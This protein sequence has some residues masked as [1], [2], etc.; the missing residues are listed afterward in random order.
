[1]I[2][3]ICPEC[4]QRIQFDSEPKI[5]QKLIC[6]TCNT[7]LLVTWLFPISLDFLDTNEQSAIPPEKGSSE[8]TFG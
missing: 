5:G 6:Q 7:A 1:M 2:N 8:G 4:Q 3:T